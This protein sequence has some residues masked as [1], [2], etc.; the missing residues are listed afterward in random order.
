MESRPASFIR[1]AFSI[2]DF[3]FFENVVVL[4]RRKSLDVQ[5]RPV[6]LD[7]PE[8]FGVER[9]VVLGQNPAYDVYF[10]N[11][12]PVV[13]LYDVHDLVH[14]VLPALLALLDQAGVGAEGAGIEADVGGLY[15]KVAV[16]IGV[17]AMPLFAD[18]VG[19]HAGVGQG[20]FFVEIQ[21]FVVAD[22]QAVAHLF[23]D[24]FE[25][26]VQP[27]VV[28]QYFQLSCSLHNQHFC[29]VMKQQ[30]RLSVFS[31]RKKSS[32]HPSLFTLHPNFIG[33]NSN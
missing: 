20:R 2:A 23:G 16:E 28:N 26:A 21:A 25:P 6:R 27:R 9:H 14:A 15:V 11:R 30:R 32:L 18:V 33:K 29:M 3:G 17:I 22:A 1:H 13:A 8:Q 10:G 12:L 24:R 31:E 7:A 5:L 4:H 19:Q